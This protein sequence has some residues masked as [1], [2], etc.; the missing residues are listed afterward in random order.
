MQAKQIFSNNALVPIPNY[1]EMNYNVNTRIGYYKD[2]TGTQRSFNMTSDAE[3]VAS[4]AIKTALDAKAN[5]AGQV[6][7]GAISAPSLQVNGR[8]VYGASQF[9]ANGTDGASITTAEANLI[10]LSFAATTPSLYIH[11][12]GCAN[13]NAAVDVYWLLRLYD[14]TSTASLISTTSGNVTGSAAGSWACR[15]AIGWSGAVTVGNSYQAQLNVLKSAS[16]PTAL[17]Y[18]TRVDAICA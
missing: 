14:V 6:F 9:G 13:I 1:G 3:K 10:A 15:F 12:Q 16:G 2:S 4:G 7:S 11:A 8:G 17:A 5:V 18:Q